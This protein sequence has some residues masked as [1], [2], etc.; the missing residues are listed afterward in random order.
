ME[1][2]CQTES[3]S[4]QLDKDWLDGCAAAKDACVGKYRG[5]ETGRQ[6]E[7]AV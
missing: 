7:E 4:K 3:F 1:F 6:R 5:G 2:Q